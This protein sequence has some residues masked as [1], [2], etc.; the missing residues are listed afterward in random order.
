M[1]N[2]V[3]RRLAA[4]ILLMYKWN[5]AFLLVV[6]ALAWKWQIF[7]KKQTWWFTD[8]AIIE[9]WLNSVVSQI[10]D[11][12]RSPLTNHDILLNLVQ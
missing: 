3:Q 10:N 2:I 12:L 1:H 9:R 6:L 8:K 4:N 7:I 5:H 11:L